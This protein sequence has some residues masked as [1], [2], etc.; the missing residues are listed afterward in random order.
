[1]GNLA[2]NE[3]S[4]DYQN[5]KNLDLPLKDMSATDFFQR[6]NSLN[7]ENFSIMDMKGVFQ[8]W[9]SNG[10]WEEGSHLVSLFTDYVPK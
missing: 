9:E 7:A 10:Y 3:N 1:M 5:I 6:V 8:E 2:S 4:A